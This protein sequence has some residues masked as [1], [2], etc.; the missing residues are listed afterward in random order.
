[1]IRLTFRAAQN[2]RRS[3]RHLV[4]QL[5]RG[6]STRPQSDGLDKQTRTTT[7][8][9]SKAELKRSNKFLLDEINRLNDGQSDARPN[10]NRTNADTTELD[11]LIDNIRSLKNL[12]SLLRSLKPHLYQLTPEHVHAIYDRINFLYIRSLIDSNVNNELAPIKKFENLIATSTVFKELTRRTMQLGDRL[13]GRCLV[14]V[15]QTWNFLNFDPNRKEVK[16][17]LDSI[18]NKMDEL[19]LME[20]LLFIDTFSRY[21]TKA[22]FPSGLYS[23]LYKSSLNVAKHMI[24]ND[25]FDRNDIDLLRMCFKVFLRIMDFNSI[26]HLTQLLLLPENRLD[27]SES[28]RF[29]KTLRLAKRDCPNEFAILEKVSLNK[30]IERCNEAIYK[31]LKS[32]FDEFNVWDYVLGLHSFR[33]KHT[34][35]LDSVYDVRILKLIAPTLIGCPKNKHSLVYLVENYARYYKYDERIVNYI[36]NQ[37]CFKPIFRRRLGISTYFILVELR[38]PFVDQQHLNK[39]FFEHC[40]DQVS[41][42]TLDYSIAGLNLLSKSILN[43]MKDGASLLHLLNQCAMRLNTKDCEQLSDDLYK[44]LNLSR[45]FFSTSVEIEKDLKSKID[46]KFA[47]ILSKILK[48]YKKPTIKNEYLNVDGRL[49]ENAYHSSGLYLNGLAIYDKSKCDLVSLVEFKDYFHKVDC[50][51]LNEN[52]EL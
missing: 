46:D 48:V 30:L 15:L 9:L 45:V 34:D 20:I 24:M 50:I 44:V 8:H 6:H 31:H 32:N 14:G 16:V 18:R 40:H 33:E 28:L 5:L 13:S 38:F 2:V 43:G 29:L 26:N 49:Q 25:K 51:P 21:S 41:K 42:L 37:F 11:E 35:D 1:M 52:Q 3:R 27:F 10:A 47:D 36:Y 39:L 12:T 17:I 7:A 4:V 23:S 19:Q 22:I